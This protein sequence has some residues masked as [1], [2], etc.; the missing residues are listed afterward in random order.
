MP[1]NDLKD[2]NTKHWIALAIAFTLVHYF[3]YLWSNFTHIASSDDSESYSDLQIVIRVQL[4]FLLVISVD[5]ILYVLRQFKYWRLVTLFVCLTGIYNGETI[6]VIEVFF[7]GIDSI[8][9]LISRWDLFSKFPW[10]L[11]S[12]FRNGIFVPLLYLLVIILI[13]L[14]WKESK[15]GKVASNNRMQ[16][17]FGNR[18]AIAS[19]AD[20]GR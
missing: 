18:Y 19:A 7:G 16:P 10:A 17:D 15:H 3:D 13:I 6:A 9:A 8:E 4:I 20:A 2:S 1:L 12:G 5:A 11:S 14:E